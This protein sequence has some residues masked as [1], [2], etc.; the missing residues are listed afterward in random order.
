V[1][2]YAITGTGTGIGKTHVACALIGALAAAGR[3]VVGWK[4]VESG[5]PDVAVPGADEAA[6][7]EASAGEGATTVR[8]V[9]PVSP[10]L[11]AR[12]MGISIDP[13][14]FV[15]TLEALVAAHEDVV[16]ELAG[17][18]YS[19][20]TDRLTNADWLA[21]L[22]TP[23]RVVLV[24]PDRLGVLHDV[25]VAARAMA[26]DEIALHAVVLSAPA[27][28]DDATGTNAAELVPRPE[29]AGV[30]VLAVPRA[31]V[32]DLVSLVTSLL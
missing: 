3:R 25:G 11:A 4:P 13:S 18:L 26:H 6:L 2:I 23:V 29:L 16:V 15:T 24:A 12:R 20:M 30:M 21:A 17:G 14:S 9:D 32:G 7:R 19:P 8:L 22:A 1:T 31:P 27:H 5:V 28:P 10:H